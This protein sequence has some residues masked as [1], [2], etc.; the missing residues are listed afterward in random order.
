[1]RWGIDA[2][3]L[4]YSVGFASES[5]PVSFALRS[6]RS[7]CTGIMNAVRAD[8][9]ELY[10][11]GDGNYRDSL[12]CD[13]YPYKGHR[14]SKKPKHYDAIKRYAIEELGAHLIE[15]EEADDR[16]SIAACQWGHGIATLDKD[17][18]CVPGWHYNW[19][20]G[21]LVNVSP[22]DADRFFYTQLLTGDPTDN[23]PGLFKRTGKKAMPKLLEPL[24]WMHEP[25]EMYAHV[26]RIYEEAYDSVGMC[27]DERDAVLD[28]W[29][30]RQGRQLWMRREE[31]E[32]WEFPSD[33]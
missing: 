1:M 7:A 27:L 25:A 31:G 22:E 24:Q 17:L 9:A 16:L 3:I 23:I 13:T 11:T 2:D 32:M 6:F 20:K 28:D 8:G 4:L 26:R 30:L 10:V 18:Y 33:G 12:G 21:L 5:D 15:G 29:L 14:P 19:S